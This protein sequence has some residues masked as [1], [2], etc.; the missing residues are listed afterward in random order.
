MD[1]KSSGT[2]EERMEALLE[3]PCFVIDPLPERVSAAR[4]VPYAAI[5]PLLHTE[6]LFGKFAGLLL[7]LNAYYDFIVFHNESWQTCPSPQAYTAW[8][9]AS[10]TAN[11]HLVFLLAETESMIVLDGE[12]T[13]M[14][15]FDPDPSLLARIRALAGAEGLFVW[16]GQ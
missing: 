3:K 2:P 9:K 11:A 5:E 1:R 10:R 14:T 16:E 8:V 13:H 15:V 12:D 4:A 6:E 7:N